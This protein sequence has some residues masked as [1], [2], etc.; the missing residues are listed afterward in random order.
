MTP[1][2]LA[3]VVDANAKKI[4]LLIGKYIYSGYNIWTTQRLDESYF[5]DTKLMGRKVQLKIDHEGEYTVNTQD[6]HSADRRDSQ[7][8]SQIM[9]VIV[10]Q[11]MSE[12]GL[13]QFGHRPRFFDASKPI[14]VK[15][16]D[17]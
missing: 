14:H 11:A 5:V 6:I 4:E 16:L 2:E 15:E 9:N 1:F 13:L 10:K 17:M 8:M 7:A 12:T 3:K